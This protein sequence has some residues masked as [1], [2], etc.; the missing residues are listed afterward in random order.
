MSN[1]L[2]ALSE[3]LHATDA[4]PQQY[5]QKFT[6]LVLATVKELLNGVAPVE[7]A[8]K[9]ERA[10]IK[11]RGRCAEVRAEKTANRHA[12]IDKLIEAG[13]RDPH[14]ILAQLQEHNEGLVRLKK[15]SKDFIDPE[16]MMRK[17]RDSKK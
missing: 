10:R 2:P 1:K 7:A 14:K 9:R 3:L 16:I 4:L 12:A 11:R 13:I 5:R 17:Y 15:G 6:V 8:L